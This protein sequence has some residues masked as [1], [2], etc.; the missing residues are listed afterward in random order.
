MSAVET[1][2]DVGVCSAVL[3]DML[4]EPHDRRRVVDAQ[5]VAVSAKS[6]FPGWLRRRIDGVHCR[7]HSRYSL[8]RPPRIALARDFV[9]LSRSK[10]APQGIDAVN[11]S[12]YMRRSEAQSDA[13]GGVLLGCAEVIAVSGC[14]G[15]E[16]GKFRGRGWVC[17][18]GPGDLLK[19][20]PEPRSGDD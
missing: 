7:A 9:V 8:P 20:S 17:D 10:W 5:P 13:D 15:N 1:Q 16:F 4:G 12:R 6:H 19:E 11:T 14:H 2:S 3:E 18:V